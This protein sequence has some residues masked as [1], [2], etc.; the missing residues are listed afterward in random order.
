MAV[1]VWWCILMAGGSTDTRTYLKP[2]STTLARSSFFLARSMA[3]FRYRAKA[4]WAGEAPGISLAGGNL[5]FVGGADFAAGEAHGQGHAHERH[6][7]GPRRSGPLADDAGHERAQAEEDAQRYRVLE[8]E[9]N[10]DVHGA[11]RG[12]VALIIPSGANPCQP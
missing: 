10:N 4:Y 5:L 9:M 8:Q 7:H 11:L 1:S 2:I 12:E 3:P 6:G